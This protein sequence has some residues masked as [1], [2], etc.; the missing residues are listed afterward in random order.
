MTV[1]AIFKGYLADREAEGVPIQRMK[2]AWKALES[3]FGACAPAHVDKPLCKQYAADRRAAGRSDG[4]IRKELSI[5]AAALN[6]AEREHWLDIEGQPGRAPFVTRPGKP[7]PRDRWLTHEEGRQLIDAAV[8]RHVRLFIVNMLYSAAR[9]TAVLELQWTQVNERFV[10]FNPP[11]AR[12]RRKGRAVVPMNTAWWAELEAARAEATCP[13]V[14]EFAGQPVKS[15]KTG[16]RAAAMR[17]GLKDVTPHVLRH[18]AATW[19]AQAGV[20]MRKISLYLGHTSV[21]T[22]ERIY[23]HHSP[24]YL[25]DGAQALVAALESP[26]P[27]KKEQAG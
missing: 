26:A 14:V 25:A 11:G 12:G 21:A 3:T 8:A 10:D 9:P 5:L 6:W 4:T 2:D 16:I 23:A 13:Y 7:P 1:G 22:T 17:A 15:V 19:M 27:A 18:T 24:S 20:D